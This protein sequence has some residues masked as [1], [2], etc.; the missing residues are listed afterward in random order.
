MIGVIDRLGWRIL[1]LGASLVIAIAAIRGIAR[2][3][4]PV[5]DN[6]LIE[7]RGRDVFTGDH[8]LLGTWS[9]ASI[10]SGIDVNHPGP[11]LFDVVAAPLRLFGTDAGIAVAI[12]IL[13]IAV[14]WAVG[15]VV[16]RT[17]GRRAGVVALVVTCGLVWT[18]GSELLY[19]PWQPN[20]LVLPFWLFMCTVWGV[21]SGRWRLLPVA[22]GVGSF[23]MQTHL[24]YLFI[25]PALLTVALVTAFVQARPGSFDDV[26]SPVLLSLGVLVVLWSQPLIEQFFGPGRGNLSRIVIAGTGGGD[27]ERV[28]STTTGFTLGIRMLGAVLALPP[29]WGRSGYDDSIPP[30]TWVEEGGERVI[31][32]PGLRT[33]G[34]SAIGLAVVGAVIGV[35]WW[36]VRRRRL[37][38]V[39]AGFITVAA[40]L[41]VATVTL[42][43]TPVDVLG[44]S[45][46]KV[47]W[48]WV[49]GAFLTMMLILAALELLPGRSTGRTGWTAD[50]RV[51]ALGAIGVVAVLAA[52][53]THTNRSGPVAFH[54]TYEGISN[55]RD[56][57]DSYLTLSDDAPERVLFDPE[58]IGFAEPYTAPVMAELTEHGVDVFV[59]ERLARQLG[60]E[61]DVDRV[62]D[63]AELRRMYV[64][65]GDAATVDDPDAVRV[66]FHPG[67]LSPYRV[68]D[69]RDRAVAVFVEGR[70]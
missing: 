35:A 5:G 4:T 41:A 32:A 36:S 61:R 34:P 13:N 65:V 23:A 50:L 21:A 18:L 60:P 43:I 2:G 22:V 19:D 45:P 6:A 26:R 9:S 53:P 25:V 57:L 51:V 1:A 63:P 27:G 64:R 3:Y 7:L 31:S 16:E 49:V 58:G 28:E 10:S 62:A 37:A 29:W 14:V 8:P 56:Q 40:S 55:V 20:V 47:R 44:L 33:L 54:A 30:S 69:I 48:I 59:D 68:D 46:H 11:L 70:S 42:I 67:D 17:A 12:A 15:L 66:A 38:V 52:L 24:S 39:D